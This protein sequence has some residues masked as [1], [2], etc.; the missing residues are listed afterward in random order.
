MPDSRA[1]QSAGNL[2]DG[3]AYLINNPSGNK[4]RT[5]LT[6]TLSK[7]GQEFDR[8]YLVRAEAELPLMRFNGKYKRIGYSYPKSL[9]WDNR[10]WVS[11]AVNKE[12]IEVTSIR[13]EDL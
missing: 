5:P 4:N 3:R 8:A 6:I 9:V 12:G 1:K 10:L 13:A 2:P 11:Y 7:D